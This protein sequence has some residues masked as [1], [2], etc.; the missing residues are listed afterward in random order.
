MKEKMNAIDY[1]IFMDGPHNQSLVGGT[2]IGARADATSSS[3]VQ[4]HPHH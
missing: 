4:H 3:L 1:K 2:S